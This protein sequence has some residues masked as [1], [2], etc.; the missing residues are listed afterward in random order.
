VCAGGDSIGD[1]Y[2]KLEYLYDAF[3]FASCFK[4]YASCDSLFLCLRWGENTTQCIY[5]K[6]VVFKA[7]DGLHVLKQRRIL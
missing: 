6:E 2:R 5:R 3:E 1:V 4:G 7:G